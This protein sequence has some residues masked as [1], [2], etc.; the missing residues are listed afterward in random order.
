MNK[1]IFTVLLTILMSMA[2][3]QAFAEMDTS[4]K[5]KVNGLYYYLDKESRG[6][7]S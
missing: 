5:I 3:Q 6:R 2:G 7:F 1:I 4:I